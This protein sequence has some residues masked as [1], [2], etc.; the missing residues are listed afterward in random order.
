MNIGDDTACYLSLGFRTIVIEA[1]PEWVK[2]AESRFAHK[3]ATR[4][5]SSIRT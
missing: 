3:F 2:H 5:L 4:R 1:N